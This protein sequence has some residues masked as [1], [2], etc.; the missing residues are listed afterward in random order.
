MNSMLTTINR[1]GANP[2]DFFSKRN[3]GVPRVFQSF[4][5]VAN[6]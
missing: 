6:T 2:M 5:C 1:G 3:F 4:E